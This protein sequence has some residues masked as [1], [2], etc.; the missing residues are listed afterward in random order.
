MQRP[1]LHFFCSVKAIACLRLK[2][3]N[4]LFIEIKIGLFQIQ[5]FSAAVNVAV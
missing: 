1:A 3:L 2:D 5:L 4:I